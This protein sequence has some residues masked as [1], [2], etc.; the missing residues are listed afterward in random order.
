MVHKK[1]ICLKATLL[2]IPVMSILW[3]ISSRTI[4]D[5]NL[6]PPPSLVL[7]AFIQMIRNGELIRDISVSLLRAL[8]GFAMSAILGIICGILTANFAVM[9]KTLGQIIELLRPV[10][11]IAFLPLFVLW[12]G[13]GELSKIII[14]AYG[15]FFPVWISTHIGIMDV[16]KSYIWA[17]RSLGAKSN[18]IFG[19]I[20]LPAAAPFI[21][22]GLRTSIGA[23]FILLI[24]AEMAGAFSGLGYRISVSHLAFRADKM[25]AAMIAL[26]IFGALAHKMFII[27]SNKVTPW[28]E[29][30]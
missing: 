28:Y 14:I 30:K 15:C 4:F 19:E 16:E 10:P 27:L 12:L 5:E 23:A 24:V 6:F 8:I 29:T 26:G 7:F 21:L 18:N 1:Q 11:A 2:T 13:I 22:I 25:L 17:A 3:E 20:I 9:R